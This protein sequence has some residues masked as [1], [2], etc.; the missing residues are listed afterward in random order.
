MR[1]EEPLSQLT[2]R[3]E[4]TFVL[5]LSFRCGESPRRLRRSPPRPSSLQPSEAYDP[6]QRKATASKHSRFTLVRFALFAGRKCGSGE[7]VVFLALL[8]CVL[9]LVDW[10]RWVA[11]PSPSLR[12]SSGSTPFVYPKGMEVT[13]RYERPVYLGAA[14]YVSLGYCSS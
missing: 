4:S 8:S 6:L 11:S 9:V 12:L 13:R 1:T 14:V 7:G 10:N 2:H 3:G 5:S